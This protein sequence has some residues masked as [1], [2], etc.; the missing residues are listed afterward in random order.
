MMVGL[1]TRTRTPAP[2]PLRIQPPLLGKPIW[3]I[4]LKTEMWTPR[5]H[6]PQ[7]RVPVKPAGT[8]FLFVI[9]IEDRDL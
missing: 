8:R 9:G 7:I 5:R 4:T 2:R 1:S 6:Q 3:I